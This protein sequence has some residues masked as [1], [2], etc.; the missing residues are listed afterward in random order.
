MEATLLHRGRAGKG[1]LVESHSLGGTTNS[2]LNCDQL[3]T[4]ARC[5]RKLS[6]IDDVSNQLQLAED[7]PMRMLGTKDSGIA[8][9]TSHS[10]RPS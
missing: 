9:F 10:L 5:C 2:E 3:R 7:Q 4:A 8:P 1:R 6:V